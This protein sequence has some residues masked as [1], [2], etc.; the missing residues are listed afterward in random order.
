MITCGFENVCVHH[1]LDGLRVGLSHFSRPSR[2]ACIYAVCAGDEPRIYDPQNLLRGHESRLAEVYLDAETWRRRQPDGPLVDFLEPAEAHDLAL[3]GLIAFGGVS[4]AVA[5]QMWF[6]EHHPD[7]CTEGPIKRWLEYAVRLFSQNCE[8]R[9]VLNLDTAEYLLQDCAVHAVRDH[10]VDER[11]RLLGL[12]TG[13]R[14]YPILDAVLGVSKTREEGAWPRG[15][16]AFVEPGFLDRVA[17]L[18][19]FPEHER[20]SLE[21][22]KHVRKLLQSVEGGDRVLV[23]DGRTLAGI[24]R[25]GL[26]P[27]TLFADF[28]G[29]HGFLRLDGDLVCSFADGNFQSSNRQA[30]LVHLEEALLETELDPA[31]QHD[32]FQAV[33]HIVAS[34]RN[35]RHGC[36]ILVDLGAAPVD[37]PGQKLAEPL[38]LAADGV[39]DLACSLARVDGAV[40]LAADLC[41]HGFGCLMDGLSVPGENRA[42]GARFNSSLRFSAQHQ[43]VVVVV[44]SSDRP[45]SVIQ[46]GVELTAQCAWVAMAGI[47]TPPFLAEWI[48]SA[49]L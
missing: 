2:V 46:G 39:L 10:I 23:S 18:T 26:P 32:L 9:N 29:G 42:R 38:D 27:A 19:R 20:P 33:S 11:S 36:A 8:F 45:V 34:A 35:H 48:A 12:D 43:Q 3:S 47:P 16:V 15:C 22:T 14:I 1:I 41:L 28:R 25:G 30:V 13:L 40:H 5:Y 44:V 6:T 7:L 21:N 31:R 17:F 49:V 37:V 24:A 4:R